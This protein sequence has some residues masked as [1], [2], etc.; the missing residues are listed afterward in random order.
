MLTA[1][2]TFVGL[3]FIAAIVIALR[4][5]EQAAREEGYHQGYGDAVRFMTSINPPQTP[6]AETTQIK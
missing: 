3:C 5:I 4:S 1:L 2:L 6:T